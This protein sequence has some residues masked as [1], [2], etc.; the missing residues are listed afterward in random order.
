MNNQKID[1]FINGLNEI[2]NNE[3]Q[4]IEKIKKE[5][6]TLIER[7][8]RLQKLL[9]EVKQLVKKLNNKDENYKCSENK[10]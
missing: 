2:L 9:D 1:N 10:E 3:L 6:F 4:S 7:N 5:K 8:N